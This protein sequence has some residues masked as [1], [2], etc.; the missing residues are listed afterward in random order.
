MTLCD[1]AHDL[2][3]GAGQCPAAF[4]ILAH[5][6][7]TP[8]WGGGNQAVNLRL[9]KDSVRDVMQFGGGACTER[10]AFAG[11]CVVHHFLQLERLHTVQCQKTNRRTDAQPQ[12]LLVIFALA[13]SNV[14]LLVGVIPL[15]SPLL[16][17]NLAG[18]AAACDQHLHGAYLGLKSCLVVVLDVLA[19]RCAIV[20]VADDNGARVFVFVSH[21]NLQNG[22]F[23][24]LRG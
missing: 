13:L 1:F 10:L 5:G 17:S 19:D 14:R 20:L 3:L 2:L 12:V 4:L 7:D 15:P 16:D 24:R 21:K 6:F 22:T 8:E 23:V 9:I 11:P 18:R